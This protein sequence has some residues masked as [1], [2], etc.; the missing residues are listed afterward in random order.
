MKITEDNNLSVT[1]K[2]VFEFISKSDES[3]QEQ[4]IQKVKEDKKYLNHIKNKV[5]EDAI[6]NLISE[7]CIKN[8]VNKKFSEVV[9]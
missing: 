4:M 5:L 8:K 2:D 7:K 3:S 6:I 1:D 9:N